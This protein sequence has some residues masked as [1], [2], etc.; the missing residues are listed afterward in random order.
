MYGVPPSRSFNSSLGRLWDVCFS[1]GI[2]GH[3]GPT[4]TRFTPALLAFVTGL[5]FHLVPKRLA[6]QL[7]S[8]FA[9]SPFNCT[10]FNNI[11]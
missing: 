9:K 10:F 7:G 3:S 8:F 11:Y 4:V 5:K 6:P 1:A 2:V